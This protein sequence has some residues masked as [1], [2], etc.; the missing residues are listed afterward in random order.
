MKSILAAFVLAAVSAVPLSAQSIVITNPGFEADAVA[1]GQFNSTITPAGWTVYDPTGVLGRDYSDVGVLNPTG[2]TLYPGGAPQGSNVALVFLWPQSSSDFNQ[3]VGLQQTLS[4]TL[5][6]STQY[7]LSVQVG[8]IAAA[9]G[10]PYDLAGFPGYRV[11]LFAGSTLLAE[12]NNTLSLT[13]GT[14]GLSTVNF[15][16]GAS[17]IALGEN[18]TI[19]LLN[20]NAPNS[21]IEVNFDDVQLVATA[22][23]EPATYALLIGLAALA[24]AAWRRTTAS[25]R[26]S[27]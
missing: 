7:S 5:Q 17:H 22:I 20:L 19:R 27:A 13:D 23:P 1:S 2:T 14:F 8:N 10:A 4:A 6:A 25:G 11:Q 3:P 18:L 15:V 26:Q 9:T 21:G 12:D 16:T 24:G